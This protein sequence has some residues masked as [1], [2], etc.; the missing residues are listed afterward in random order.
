MPDD[1]LT[2]IFNPSGFDPSLA[3]EG[4]QCIQTA[5]LF[6]AD[7]KIKNQKAWIDE[8]DRQITKFEPELKKHIIRREDYTTTDVSRLTRDGVVPGQGGE[9]IGLG[10]I[11]GQ[12]GQYK[13]SPK[14]P[15]QGLFYVGVD[16]GGY[17]VGIHHAT[18]SATKVAPEVLRY[19][20]TH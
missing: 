11:V 15:I 4:K 1:M 19:F 14:S 2:I 3:P 8:F 10:Q 7:P 16:A 6:P 18:D 5:T 20:Q 17:G 13:P 12:C 9:C